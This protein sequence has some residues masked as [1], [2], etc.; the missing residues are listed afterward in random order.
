MLFILDTCLFW[1]CLFGL[2]R[3]HECLHP[4]IMHL[5]DP[6]PHALLNHPLGGYPLL[7]CLYSLLSFLFFLLYNF[8]VVSFSHVHF[9]ILDID[10]RFQI[11]NPWDPHTFDPEISL[12]SLLVL[13]QGQSL[14]GVYFV[15][16][17]IIIKTVG[18]VSDWVVLA[19]VIILL[20]G[21]RNGV[22]Q[23]QIF[24]KWDVLVDV[25]LDIVIILEGR[26]EPEEPGEV[27]ADVTDEEVT[28]R[29]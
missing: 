17:F 4:L 12:P 19:V 3:D 20:T 21:H 11:S 18:L 15:Q 14:L 6:L 1:R 24:S 16:D 9:L 25:N 26:V 13:Y 28:E 5:L 27:V 10:L 22:V 8:L 7:D 2:C 23:F 29:L